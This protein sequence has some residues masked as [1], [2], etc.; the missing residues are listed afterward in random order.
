VTGG[1][2]PDGA[3]RGREV[4]PTWTTAEWEL[5]SGAAA[6]AGATPAAWAARVVMAGLTPGHERAPS[7]CSPRPVLWAQI[8]ERWQSVSWALVGL[9]DRAPD[10]GWAQ[11][12][13]AAGRAGVVLTGNA[14][15]VARGERR[16][17][18]DACRAATTSLLALGSGVRPGARLIRLRDPDCGVHRA[19]ILLTPH[20]RAA[21]SGACGP[22][23][24][25]AS[26]YVAAVTTVTAR[27]S[28]ELATG[29]DLA[30]IEGL[31]VVA[32]SAGSAAAA[33]LGTAGP[34]DAAAWATMSGLVTQ[35]WTL[36]DATRPGVGSPDP[37]VDAASLLPR[38]LAD[39]GWPA[40]M[41]GTSP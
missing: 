14:D 20:A 6:M 18:A 24:W 30:R 22:R 21:L 32:Q 2:A 19:K 37:T 35:A 12:S 39:L 38:A 33:M 34:V 29:D 8:L 16:Q 28:L 17:A 15:V 41:P 27:M 31:L 3:V 40:P 10:A 26:D 36:V 9:R 13:A 25:W 1:D 5:V 7:R 23:G 11:V 4:R